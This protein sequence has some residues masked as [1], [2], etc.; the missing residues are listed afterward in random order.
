MIQRGICRV[1]RQIMIWGQKQLPILKRYAP[2]RNSWL[3]EQFGAL[4]AFLLL[5]LTIY[6]GS[7]GLFDVIIMEDTNT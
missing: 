2:Q 3:I 5:A 6:I 1:N 4:L 7:I